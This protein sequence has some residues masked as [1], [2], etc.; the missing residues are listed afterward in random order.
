MDIPGQER[1]DDYR[2]RNDDQDDRGGSDD[3]QRPF[4]PCPSAENTA[5]KDW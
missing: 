1:G 5:L 2:R 3:H 4:C